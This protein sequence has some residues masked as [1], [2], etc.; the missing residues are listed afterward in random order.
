[1][2]VFEGYET[3]ERLGRAWIPNRIRWHPNFQVC[4]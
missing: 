2:I 3:S 4:W 1:M